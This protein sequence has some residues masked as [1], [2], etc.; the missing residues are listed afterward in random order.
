MI[1]RVAVTGAQGTGKSSFARTL[2]E[3]CS[4]K[5]GPSKLLN[6]TGNA[7]K[8]KGI[9]VGHLAGE[10]AIRAFWSAHQK[11]HPSEG[12]NIFDRCF[13]DIVAYS[14]VL[15]ALGKMDQ[16]LLEAT[17]RLTLQEFNRIF[18]LPITGPYPEFRDGDE[19]EEFREAIQ[20]EIIQAA[21][22]FELS[23]ATILKDYPHVGVEIIEAAMKQ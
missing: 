8:S 19:P 10:E 17:A 23:Y 12:I 21:D 6:G 13:L 22:D 5:I 1:F 15:G 9:V 11:Q 2:Y 3:L 7:V 16:D 18:I 20:R 4:H 14:R